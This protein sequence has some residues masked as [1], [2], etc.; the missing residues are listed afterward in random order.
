[1]ARRRIEASEI[2]SLPE[3]ASLDTLLGA[4]SGSVEA[5]VL[6]QGG[7]LYLRIASGKATDPEMSEEDIQ[8]KI[9]EWKDRVQKDATNAGFRKANK[10]RGPM[11]PRRFAWQL[12]EVARSNASRYRSPSLLRLAKK[13]RWVAG[14]ERGV[15]ARALAKLAAPLEEEA[16]RRDQMGMP[17]LQ[18]PQD[19]VVQ[20]SLD[21]GQ[22]A[23]QEPGEP[24]PGEPIE[25][26]LDE[27]WRLSGRVA[28]EPGEEEP[29]DPR[30]VRLASDFLQ[31]YRSRNS[32]GNDDLL[33]QVQDEDVFVAWLKDLDNK[34]VKPDY[35]QMSKAWNA[36]MDEI[37]RGSGTSLTKEM[38]GRDIA[39]GAGEDL[40]P[41]SA[42]R[43]GET[44]I[45]RETAPGGDWFNTVINLHESPVMDRYLR[46]MR[47]K[48]EGKTRIG[49]KIE[50]EDEIA[51]AVDQTLDHFAGD[52]LPSEISSDHVEN[53]VGDHFPD[54]S[55][56]KVYEAIQQIADPRKRHEDDPK[57]RTNQEAAR[58]SRV[59][60][61]VLEKG[62]KAEVCSREKTGLKRYREIAACC[63]GTGEKNG[64]CCG[65]CHG[66][67]QQEVS[68]FDE[69]LD[70]KVRV[71]SRLGTLLM[72]SVDVGNRRISAADR[73]ELARV[74]GTRVACN[75][76][77]LV[78]QHSSELMR[79]LIE[80]NIPYRT[81]SYC[82]PKYRR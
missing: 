68:A 74:T 48:R 41:V 32:L 46:D 33:D 20:P 54:V 65:R 36:A 17:Q 27:S 45:Q 7:D 62:Q 3:S 24:A 35:Q 82:H 57:E 21:F 56:A 50:V 40:K 2:F 22:P 49:R 8:A 52:M 11:D 44:T 66:S 16:R 53:F 31:D 79:A 25:N 4:Y 61:T 59:H 70:R 23:R 14:Q 28:Q 39:P 78:F 51:S 9:A 69:D 38:E 6:D 47:D 81:V 63:H 72:V 5:S 55:A 34:G 42:T 60:L 30:L 29:A 43:G 19:R 73:Q 1:M 18:R 15:A 10:G 58:R 80:H 37:A 77:L 13:L 75:G 67:G 64:R 12:A 71:A 26:K 76:K